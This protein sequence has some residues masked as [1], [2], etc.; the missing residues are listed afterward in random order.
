VWRT[1]DWTSPDWPGHKDGAPQVALLDDYNPPRS[2][3]FAVETEAD[4]ER[5]RYLFAEPSAE[6][7]A[8]FRE[9]AGRLAAQARELDVLLVGWGPGGG[10]LVVWLCG[11]TGMI[12]MAK[13]RPAL[14]EELMEIIHA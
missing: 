2:R 8:R 12:L 9:Q 13:E 10:D 5:A 11:V 4:V 6:A 14:F 1:D 7:I 3:R